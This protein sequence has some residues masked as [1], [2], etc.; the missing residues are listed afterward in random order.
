MHTTLE[1]N[2]E[3]SLQISS[4]QQSVWVWMQRVS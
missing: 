2:K 3:P 4:V 1:K